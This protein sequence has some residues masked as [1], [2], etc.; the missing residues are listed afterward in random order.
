MPMTGSS[1]RCDASYP[2]LCE[3]LRV[4]A[5]YCGSTALTLSMHT[6]P[7]ATL[8][9]R[10]RRDPAPR[11]PL[12]ARG[13]W[14]AATRDQRRIG[15]ARRLRGRGPRRRRL[16][17]H[18][19]EAFRQWQPGW[20]SSDDH[21]RGLGLG[22]GTGCPAFRHSAGAEGV[23]VLDNWRTLGM[24]GT[25]SHDVVIADVHV[26][27]PAISMRRPP[28]KWVPPVQVMQVIALPLVRAAMS[29]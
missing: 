11:T 1:L 27:Q 2:E 8:V 14:T 12:A 6:H 20:R 7:L 21:R 23:T 24:R 22:T 9:W 17:D 5:R 15:P 13:R 16:A 10:W 28:G 25:G 19:E 18:R 29:A 3:M 4:L 26:P